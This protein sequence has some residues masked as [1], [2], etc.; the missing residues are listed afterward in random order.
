MWA[1]ANSEAFDSQFLNH[2]FPVVINIATLVKHSHVL[3]EEC[4]E[5]A[6]KLEQLREDR[7]HNNYIPAELY[8]FI[9]NLRGEV[10]SLRSR[11]TF[12]EAEI[13]EAKKAKVVAF[14][15]DSLSAPLLTT[16]TSGNNSSCTVVYNGSGHNF[17]ISSIPLHRDRPSL[18]QVDIVS[19]P[20][21]RWVLLGVVGELQPDS[22]SFSV[23]SCYAWGSNNSVYVAGVLQSGLGSWGTWQIGD[24]GVFTYCPL[25]ATLS[26]R[27]LR[28]GS[29]Q[30]FSID[31]CRLSAAFIHSNS[32]ATGTSLRFSSAI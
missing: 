18:W 12:L 3:N 1:E 13:E 15:F 30:E 8:R 29:S 22:N 5:L 6:Q 24:R 19:I 9:V 32:N 25:T 16:V 10:V 26:L 31:N 20:A 28:G 21:N 17:A 7:R 11:L 14:Q 27:L 23:D 2:E 4:K